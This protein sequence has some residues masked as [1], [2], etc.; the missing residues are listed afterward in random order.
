MRILEKVQNVPEGDS[1]DDLIAD[2]AHSPT[3]GC[4]C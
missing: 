1:G 3:G 4:S 2:L